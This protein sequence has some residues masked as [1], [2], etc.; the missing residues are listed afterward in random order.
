MIT[1]F[2]NRRGK[3]NLFGLDLGEVFGEKR[4]ERSQNCLKFIASCKDLTSP[5]S[6]DCSGE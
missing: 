2:R 5:E 4:S 3:Y 6:R 1:G